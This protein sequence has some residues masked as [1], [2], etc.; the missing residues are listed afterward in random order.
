LYL[1]RAVYFNQQIKPVQWIALILTYAG[2]LVAFAGELSA[3]NIHDE[4]FFLGAVLIFSCAITFALY[5][6]GS[7]RIIPLVGAA[8]F[9][10]YA[11]SFAA[12]GVLLHYLISSSPSL[13]HLGN[14]VYL[15]AFLMAIISTVIPSYLISE[16]IKRIGSG[17]AAIIAS[18]GPVST[19]VQAYIFLDEPILAMQIGGTVLI[20]IGVMLV[21]WKPRRN[22]A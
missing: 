18:V 5:I 12:A 17:N 21:G 2:L 19:I 10:S 7:G 4:N 11:M 20:L 16:G 15:Y 13:T 22:L 3:D 1:F 6:V 14:T 8:K 9:N